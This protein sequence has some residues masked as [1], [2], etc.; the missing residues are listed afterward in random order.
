MMV[1]LLKRHV[2]FEVEGTNFRFY[3]RTVSVEFMQ[4]MRGL[5]HKPINITKLK[6]YIP[7]FSIPEKTTPACVVLKNGVRMAEGIIPYWLVHM[8]T[9]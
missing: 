5:Q 7:K 4:R 9:N 3:K 2:V 1:P 6:D 8:I